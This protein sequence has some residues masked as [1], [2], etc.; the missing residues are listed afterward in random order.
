MGQTPV[1]APRLSRREKVSVAASLW[2]TPRRRQVR[3][4]YWTYSNTYITAEDYAEY[5]RNL[6]QGRL[7]GRPVTVL[8]DEGHM[9]SGEPIEE[10]L[11]DFPLLWLEFMP[12][13]APELNPVEAV[14]HHLK[15][16]KLANFVP[17]DF[18]HLN[19][20]LN[21]A[22]LPIPDDQPRL[23]TFLSASPLVW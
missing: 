21:Q 7:R 22:L 12:T 6:M 14:W 20:V 2:K 3:L 23:Q 4:H 10:I 8:H 9:H 1:V 13:Y 15:C 18:P 17:D 5:L 16:D 19:Q 11:E